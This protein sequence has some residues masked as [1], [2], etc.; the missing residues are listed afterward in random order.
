MNV[1]AFHTKRATPPSRQLAVDRIVLE[2]PFP[3]P[4]IKT[5][6]K[7][8]DALASFKYKAG[9]ASRT[10][11]IAEKANIKNQS[12]VRGILW[13][14]IRNG[15]IA[16]YRRKGKWMWCDRGTTEEMLEKHPHLYWT[17]DELPK[18]LNEA[19]EEDYDHPI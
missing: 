13:S 17:Y 18:R 4:L 9:F 12:H 3:V 11:D 16:A 1:H 8:Y 7:I 6:Q 5:E 2:E 10:S 14:L 19:G 15:E